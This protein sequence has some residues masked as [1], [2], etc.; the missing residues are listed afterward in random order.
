MSTH[1]NR[2]TRASTRRQSQR[3]GGSSTPS[4]SHTVLQA[5]GDNIALGTTESVVPDDG[6]VAEALFSPAQMAAVTRMIEDAHRRGVEQGRREQE[7]DGDA[8]QQI[9]QQ[10]MRITREP[11]KGTLQ[12]SAN[13]NACSHGLPALAITGTPASEHQHPAKK[14]EST[15]VFGVPE[16]FDWIMQ[17]VDLSQLFVNLRVSRTW[18]TYLSR[19][20]ALQQ[21]MFLCPISVAT[22]PSL[23]KVNPLAAHLIKIFYNMAEDSPWARSEASWRKMLLVNPVAARQTINTHLY[24]S[25]DGRSLLDSVN[26]DQ[27]YR[28]MTFTGLANALDRMS[29]D[30]YWRTKLIT[31]L[32][33]TSGSRGNFPEVTLCTLHTIPLPDVRVPAPTLPLEDESMQELR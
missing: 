25:S 10:E 27:R 16:L 22:D 17:H 29:K 1:I 4:L 13:F 11:G 20:K 28:S 18:F 26:G 30:K 7:Q 33:V 6:E 3:N 8:C 5:S 32:T 2:T 9:G 21:K 15:T 23:V 19:S 24:S 14:P 12:N 31:K